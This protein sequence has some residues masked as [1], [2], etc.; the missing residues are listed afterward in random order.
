MVG[1]LRGLKNIA[2]DAAFSTHLTGPVNRLQ[3][4][5]RL[6]GTGGSVSGALVLDT[7]VP[8][9]H[10]SGAVD[11]GLDLARWL[12]RADRPSDITGH[13]VFNLDLDL[14][15]HFPRGTYEFDGPHVSFMDYA[16]DRM[17]AHGRLTATEVQIADA[18]A[19][20]YGA[21][22]A[23]TAGSTIGLDEPFPFH[24]VGTIKD[25]DLRQ[26]PKPVRFRMS[27]AG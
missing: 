26:L 7:S 19:V 2:V 25:I 3:T 17:R 9:W 16:A 22:V 13:V 24:F 10:G 20:A 4:D 6:T 23:A 1:H 15:H 27:R 5:L 8:G 14:G 21:G 12:N 11:I 18:T